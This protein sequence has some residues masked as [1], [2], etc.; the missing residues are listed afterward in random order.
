ML[1]VH[2]RLGKQT[3]QVLVLHKTMQLSA[4]TKNIH[5][6]LQ[7]LSTPSHTMAQ[8][9][10]TYKCCLVVSLRKKTIAVFQ[11]RSRPHGAAW[12]S[13]GNSTAWCG[14]HVSSGIW[15]QP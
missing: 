9:H 8:K 7:K 10:F 6:G 15:V 4:P 13:A 5:L 11:V 1:S 12:A 3:T 14:S 2:L